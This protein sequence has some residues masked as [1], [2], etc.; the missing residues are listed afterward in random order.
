MTQHLQSTNDT[1]FTIKIMT[2]NVYKYH[3]FLQRTLHHFSQATNTSI[4]D[5]SWSGQLLQL[6]SKSLQIGLLI[7]I[8]L[9]L[10]H[11]SK[12]VNKI[13]KL[14]IMVQFLLYFCFKCENSA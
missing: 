13:L 9:K 12:L 2:S 14:M 11:E 3:D 10:R 8:I 5:L 7:F 1:V 4:S 6:I